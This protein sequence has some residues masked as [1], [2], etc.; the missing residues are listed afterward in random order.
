MPTQVDINGAIVDSGPISED[1]GSGS[2]DSSMPEVTVTGHTM[3]WPV[4]VG[5][6]LLVGWLLFSKSNRRKSSW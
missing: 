3:W 4:W 5:A 2:G 6:G 1:S